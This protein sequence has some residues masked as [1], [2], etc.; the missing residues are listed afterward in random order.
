ME[1]LQNV[2]R[3]GVQVQIVLL[4]LICKHRPFSNVL[5]LSVPNGSPIAFGIRSRNT[6][7]LTLLHGVPMVL[8]LEIGVIYLN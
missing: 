2:I 5:E 7:T 4:L 6:F 1:I 8:F 3:K